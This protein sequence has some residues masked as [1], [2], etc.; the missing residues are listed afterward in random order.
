MIKE[1]DTLKGV[2]LRSQQKEKR[3]YV[4]PGRDRRTYA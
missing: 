1:I 2:S 4:F 3:T